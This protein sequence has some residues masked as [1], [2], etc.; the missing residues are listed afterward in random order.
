MSE[1][2]KQRP[3]LSELEMRGDFIRRHIGPDKHQIHEMLEE[4]GMESLDDVVDKVVPENILIKE[5]LSLTATMSER[6][7]RTYIRK[8]RARNKV[9]VSMITSNC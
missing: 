6:S 4:L 9:F 8:I 7:V 2:E 1:N 5:P 3:P